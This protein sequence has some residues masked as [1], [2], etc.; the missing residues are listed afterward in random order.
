METV[1]RMNSVKSMVESLT[2]TCDIQ[3]SGHIDG[4]VSVDLNIGGKGF[5]E[6]L[7]FIL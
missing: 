5:S 6:L 4:F 3:L 2:E 7:L 1:R